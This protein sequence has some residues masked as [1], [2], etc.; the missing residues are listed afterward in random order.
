MAYGLGL[1]VS[2]FV[3]FFVFAEA[4]PADKLARISA[5][6]TK[7]EVEGFVGLPELIRN[8]SGG[9]TTFC[10]G[11]YQRLRWCSAEIPVR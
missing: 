6:M 9:S 10:Y 11:G 7:S 4:V 3:G 8:E 1:A 2:G 5:G